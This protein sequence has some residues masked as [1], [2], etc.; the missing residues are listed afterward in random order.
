VSQALVIPLSMNI[1]NLT[2]PNLGVFGWKLAPVQADLT[3]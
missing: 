2:F 3:R 1:H